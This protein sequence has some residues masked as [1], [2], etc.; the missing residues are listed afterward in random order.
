[1]GVYETRCKEHIVDSSTVFLHVGSRPWLPDMCDMVT[2]SLSSDFH[3]P[4]TAKPLHNAARMNIVANLHLVYDHYRPTVC[5][6]LDS[7]LLRI[8]P[9][10][11]VFRRDSGSH[12]TLLLF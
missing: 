10:F 4:A 11:S 8:I 3:V 5:W 1:M 2:A 9:Q 7:T 12:S 6:G